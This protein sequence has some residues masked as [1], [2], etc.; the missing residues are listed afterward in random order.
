[1][2]SSGDLVI[3]LSSFLSLFLLLLALINIFLTQWWTPT[4][5]Q[6]LMGRQGIKGPCYR[7]FQGN[8][9]QISDMKNEA[10]SRPKSL[11]HDLFPLVQPHYKLWAKIYGNK[12]DRVSTMLS[13]FSSDIN[14]GHFF[15]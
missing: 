4:R 2:T 3:M 8:N 5:L 1:M 7:L 13:N 12:L 9:K 10:I 6:K 14:F 15:L 11:S